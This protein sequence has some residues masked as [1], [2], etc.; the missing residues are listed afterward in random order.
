[1]KSD[2]GR[3]Q[4]VSAQNIGTKEVVFHVVR[5][6]IAEATLPNQVLQI[7][8]VHDQAVAEALL[9]IMRRTPA[10]RTGKETVRIVER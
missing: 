9:E 2:L 10:V 5:T 1:M 6:R 3:G 7:E 8:T 4:I